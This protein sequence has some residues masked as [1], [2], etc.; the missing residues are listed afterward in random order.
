MLNPGY[1]ELDRAVDVAALNLRSFGAGVAV[2]REQ[3]SA[4]WAHP[5][6][7]PTR[8]PAML[9]GGGVGPRDAVSVA[10]WALPALRPKSLT[11][12]GN[13]DIKLMQALNTA[14]VSGEVRRVLDRFLA[15]V[16]LDDTG[17]TSNASRYC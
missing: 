6:Q 2:R 17:Q 9:A 7:M 11:L 14:G 15:G 10:R 4:V 8:V 1:P 16:L 3:S 5:L 13:P 12:P